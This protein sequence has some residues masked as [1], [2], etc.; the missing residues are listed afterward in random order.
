MFFHTLIDIL[1]NSILITGL[2]IV[3]MMMIEALNIESHGR[4]FSR[5][6]KT[7]F[8]QVLFGA[9]LGLI[10]GCIGGFATVSLY[11]HGLF[12]FGALVAM[13]I[14]SSG[15]EA[16]MMLAMFPQKALILFGVLFV[17]AVVTGVLTDFAGERLR[18]KKGDAAMAQEQG[19]CD[20]GFEIHEHEDT[21]PRGQ[22]HF[23]W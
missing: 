22:R 15:D 1:R 11:T 9:T 5:L 12:S 10:P 4:F 20:E 8:G 7:R 17:I 13:M 16:F 2:V 6:R 21:K 14:A 18:K 23:G 3:M 19:G